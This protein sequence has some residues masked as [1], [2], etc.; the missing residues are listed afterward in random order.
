M[1]VGNLARKI[2]KN[3]KLK[4]SE[5]RTKKNP[6]SLNLGTQFQIWERE[7]LRSKTRNAEP[8]NFPRENEEVPGQLAL[9]G[10]DALREDDLRPAHHPRRVI[11]PRHF[12]SRR[13]RPPPIPRRKF[14]FRLDLLAIN[15]MLDLAYRCIIKENFASDCLNVRFK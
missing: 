12:L 7:S 14:P 10:S 2:S 9:Y 5:Y 1:A 13:T 11:S 15:F 6:H 8:E 4:A 3:P